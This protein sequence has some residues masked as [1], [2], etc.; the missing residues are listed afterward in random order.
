MPPNE[1]IAPE[2]VQTEQPD[3]KRLKVLLGI[4]LFVVIFGGAAVF[5]LKKSASPSLEQIQQPVQQ[6]T[7]EIKKNVSVEELNAK[8]NEADIMS[9]GTPRM[10]TKEMNTKLNT[11]TKN[12]SQTPPV[13]QSEMQAKLDALAQY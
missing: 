8:L 1:N 11:T 7:P 5:L 3:N 4:L 12:A 13:S 10:T 2:V 9:S 6:T